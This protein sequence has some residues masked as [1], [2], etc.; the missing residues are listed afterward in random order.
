M[1]ELLDRSEY[2]RMI[3]SSD[4]VEGSDLADK[5]WKSY[6]GGDIDLYYLGFG[7]DC[8]TLKGGIL[9]AIIIDWNKCGKIF[10]E[11]FIGNWEGNFTKCNLSRTE[12]LEVAN[13][14]NI[15]P[16]G[17]ATCILAAKHLEYMIASAK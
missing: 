2:Q 1:E 5:V 3:F 12:L 7:L 15:L 14:P 10:E 9:S 13:M 4:A 16:F 8:L 6:I 17:A 11:D